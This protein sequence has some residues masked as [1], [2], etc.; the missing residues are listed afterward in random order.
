M[1]TLRQQLKSA[2]I[3]LSSTGFATFS[4][5]TSLE[6]F[7]QLS[8]V[9]R[10]EEKEYKYNWEITLYNDMGEYI[11]K[12]ESDTPNVP[13]I[14]EFLC[15]FMKKI[16]NDPYEYFISTLKSILV[17]YEISLKTENPIESGSEY[18]MEF[19]NGFQGY[20]D[21]DKEAH[22]WK[23][24]ILR[25]SGVIYNEYRNKSLALPPLRE[26]FAKTIREIMG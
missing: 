15:G 9:V 25:G 7:Q 16:G 4:E 23:I 8:D 18:Y 22:I 11:E 17:K 10:K 2:N 14:K 5:F 1:T 19:K 20:M 12:A 13:Y 21:I 3:E 26:F 6:Q 24:R